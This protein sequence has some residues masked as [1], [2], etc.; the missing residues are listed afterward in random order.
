MR[1]NIMFDKIKEWAKEHGYKI[2]IIQLPYIQSESI[3]VFNGKYYFAY[4]DKLGLAIMKSDSDLITTDNGRMENV[5]NICTHK[6]TNSEYHEL[7]IM[8]QL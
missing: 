6:R 8:E 4:T 3:L 1:I 7:L 5:T 2:K